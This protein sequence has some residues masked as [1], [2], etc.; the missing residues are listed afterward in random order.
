M[1][2][3]TGNTSGISR[4]KRTKTVAKPTPSQLSYALLL[5]AA[6]LAFGFYLGS[7]KL[8]LC[9]GISVAL[10]LT[11]QRSRFCFTAALRDPVLTGGT[12]LTKA[13]VIG[14]A[15]GTVGFSAVQIGAYFKAGEMADAVKLAH[16]S[17]VG[18]H[19]AIGAFLFGI[20]AVIAGGCA[21]GTLMRVGE[22]YAQNMI[23]LVAFVAGSGI[24]AASWP[25]WRDLLGV[26]LA[27]TVYL[28]QLLGGFLP[29]LLVQFG[30]L[31]AIWLAADW[32]NKRKTARS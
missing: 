10:G 19:T 27:N 26:N 17:P 20:G 9:W 31:F 12:S 7:P 21:S 28:P 24:A 6:I 29:A 8:S 16:L 23:A 30:L 13:V 15:V 2:A 3:T 4:I 18:I 11:L 25:I 32:W 22:G 1:T 5:L 14:L